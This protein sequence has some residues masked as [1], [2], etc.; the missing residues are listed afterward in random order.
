MLAL[1]LALI[2]CANPGRQREHLSD[3]LGPQHFV[4]AIKT[5]EALEDIVRA[6]LTALHMQPEDIECVVGK[7][8]ALPS[9]KTEPPELL[10][11][12]TDGTRFAQECGV[13]ISKLYLVK[14]D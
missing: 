9:W 2:G 11:S 10:L 13:E 6:W 12:A 5:H 7:I 1:P 8:K 3:E 14:H 4:P